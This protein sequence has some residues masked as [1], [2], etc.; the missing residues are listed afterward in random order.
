MNHVKLPALV[1]VAAMALMALLGAGTASATVLCKTATSGSPCPVGESYSGTIK[2]SLASGTSAVSKDTSGNVIDTCTGGSA[3]GSASAG[4]ATS[5]VTGSTTS[6]S[7]TGCSVSTKVIKQCEGEIHYISGTNSGTVTVKGCEV[8]TN[9][10]FFGSCVYGLSE[11][12][13]VG[14]IEEGGSKE[15]AIVS[16]VVNKISGGISCPSTTVTQA[17]VVRTSPEGTLAIAPS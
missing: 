5:T 6:L 7:L 17:S 8:T 16:Q 1:A 2:G 13:D 3:E 9:T 11:S 12:T 10:V 4:G 15:A 14:I